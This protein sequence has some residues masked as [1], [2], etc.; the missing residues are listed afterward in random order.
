MKTKE[1]ILAC[2]LAT[3]GALVVVFILW[4]MSV[5]SWAIVWAVLSFGFIPI[6]I[7]AMN[8][9]QEH[10]CYDIDDFINALM[11]YQSESKEQDS[12]KENRIKW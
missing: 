2:V 8:F 10:D 12:L 6:A 1:Y 4:L 7:K 9:Y 3:V 5:I 11:E